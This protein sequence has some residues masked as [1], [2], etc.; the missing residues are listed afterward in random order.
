MGPLKKCEYV[1]IDGIVRDYTRE[2]LR[3]LH[4]AINMRI[5]KIIKK[6]LDVPLTHAL[7]RNDIKYVKLE[8][9]V[10]KSTSGHVFIG[11]TFEFIPTF[12]V[13]F[14]RFEKIF[15]E[16]TT[17][18]FPEPIG[19]KFRLPIDYSTPHFGTLFEANDVIELRNIKECEGHIEASICCSN[20]V[21]QKRV[22]HFDEEHG[23]VSISP[24]EFKG[25]VA[26]NGKVYLDESPI[27]V[28]SMN[29]SIFDIEEYMV[30]N[31]GF[32]LREVL[33][34]APALKLSP[35]KLVSNLTPTCRN[36][37]PDRAGYESD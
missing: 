36:D 4:V 13:P 37:V 17:D 22:L 35:P 16:T 23:G 1:C 34:A 2:E 3:I 18:L 21:Y 9:A 20:E 14:C 32:H 6:N 30:G 19:Y 5:D 24:W 26:L 11:C 27:T 15:P 28:L 31:N 12:L 25:R 33:V 29:G 8:N 10:P 7:L